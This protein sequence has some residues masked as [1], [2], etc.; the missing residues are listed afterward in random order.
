MNYYGSPLDA[1]ART[2]AVGVIAFVIGLIA[3]IVIF[4]A[5]L[6]PRNDG[7]YTGAAAWFYEFLNFRKLIVDGLLR[8]LYIALSITLVIYSFLNIFVGYGDFFPKV[9]SFFGISIF[10]NLLL[11]IVYELLMMFVIVCRN[12]SDINR[13]LGNGNAPVPPNGTSA[14]PNGPQNPQTPKAPAAPFNQTPVTSKAS[15][16]PQNPN[17]VP[18]APAAPQN[19]QV[20]QNPN[21]SAAPFGQAPTASKPQDSQGA[22]PFGQAPAAS[23]AQDSQGAAPFGQ[24]PAAPKAPEEPKSN[25]FQPAI[26]EGA[27]PPAAASQQPMT[28]FCRQ[29]GQRFTSDKDAC[30]YCGTKRV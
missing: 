6:S 9:L 23:K 19:Q 7:K 21:P 11:R 24:A 13:K 8:V 10:G 15:A 22:A 27:Q 17:A 20:P 2:G 5:F 16:V 3:A 12:T 25:V 29:C 18:K 30:P 4:V 14:R 26:Q 1:L 28:V